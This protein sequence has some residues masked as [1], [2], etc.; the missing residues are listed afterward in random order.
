MEEPTLKTRSRLL[1][2][3]AMPLVAVPLLAA[4][5][6]SIPAAADAANLS[7]AQAAAGQAQQ[8]T[9]QA[10]SQALATSPSDAALA[11]ASDAQLVGLGV[12][13]V[14]IDGLTYCL[15]RG[16]ED[17][18]TAATADVQAAETTAAS[19]TTA[20]ADAASSGGDMSLVTYLHSWAS[21]SQADRL[22]QESTELDQA[23]AAA[24]KEVFYTDVVINQQTLPADFATEFPD[25]ASWVPQATTIL[26]N[27]QRLTTSFNDVTSAGVTPDVP[28]PEYDHYTAFSDTSKMRKQEKGNWCGPTSLQALVWNSPGST[29][30]EGKYE[31]QTYWAGKL[32]VTAAGTS[33]YIGTLNDEINYESGWDGR[34]GDYAV[35]SIASWSVTTWRNQFDAHLGVQHAPIQLHPIL[36][37][38]DNDYYPTHTS[39]HFD[40]GRGYDYDYLAGLQHDTVYLFEPAGGAAEGN[41]YTSVTAT[42][43]TTDI[44]LA[45]L[46]NTTQRNISY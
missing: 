18:A 3:V 2:L 10:V 22:A 11:A 1:R 37:S 29:R 34:A 9:A 12:R 8:A 41:V 31:S 6:L 16:W 39:G 30:D 38:S 24:G 15:H 20:D 46:A 21:L 36:N 14:P 7:D 26:A 45:N 42:D 35:H 27:E 19:M 5:S 44:R 17:S 28:A 23:V 13:C 4:L 43:T 33:T 32:G 25:L 40:V